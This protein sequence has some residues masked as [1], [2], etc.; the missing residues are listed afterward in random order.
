[1]AN[2]GA[3]DV[4]ALLQ[5]LGV[6]VTVGAA[7][8]KGLVDRADGQLLAENGMAGLVGRAVV[9]TVQTGSL[10]GVA[11]E[12]AITVDG[13]ALKVRSVRVIEDGEITQVLCAES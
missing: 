5:E 12:G 8:V 7:T 10:P 1:M 2:F 6:D 11:E 9:V 4:P 3:G 13:A